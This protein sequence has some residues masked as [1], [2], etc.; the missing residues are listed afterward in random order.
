VLG[1]VTYYGKDQI[2]YRDYSNTGHIKEL[3]IAVNK[4]KEKPIL[5][6]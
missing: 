2:I 4:I 6:Q 3:V 1:V 5:G